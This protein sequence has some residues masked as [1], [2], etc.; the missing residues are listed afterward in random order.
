MGH[1]KSADAA[2]I[3]NWK[4]TVRRY[5]NPLLVNVDNWIVIKSLLHEQK[6]QKLLQILN[7][8]LLNGLKVQVDLFLT[9]SNVLQSELNIC[10]NSDIYIFSLLSKIVTI[11]IWPSGILD[12]SNK[13][14]NW[15]ITL[16]SPTYLIP[17][18]WFLFISIIPNKQ[19]LAIQRRKQS[20]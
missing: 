7:F 11:Q 17:W 18:C 6:L 3:K 16:L 9:A 4:G 19:K 20:K 5:Q 8:Q 2:K 10:Q 1:W 12:Y 15:T 14:D 13:N